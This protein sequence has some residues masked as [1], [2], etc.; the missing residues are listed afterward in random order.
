L[1]VVDDGWFGNRNDD[2]TSLG[3]WVVNLKKFPKG[4]KGL[5]EEVNA[6]GCKFGIW[7]EPEMVSKKSVK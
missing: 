3:D 4:L 6:A 2:Q 7:V 1:I 5:V